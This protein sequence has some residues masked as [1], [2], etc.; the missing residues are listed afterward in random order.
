MSDNYFEV[1]ENLKVGARFDPSSS[2]I[3][4]PAGT[5]TGAKLDQILKNFRENYHEK[6]SCKKRAG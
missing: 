3:T 4:L 1:K 5:Y 6:N 2:F